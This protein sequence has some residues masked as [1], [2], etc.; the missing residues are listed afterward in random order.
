M[1]ERVY[2]SVERP[3]YA[4][5]RSNRSRKLAIGMTGVRIWKRVTFLKGTQDYEKRMRMRMSLFYI[6]YSRASR[7]VNKILR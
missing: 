3:E 6:R 1:L 7:V 5:G 2:E 4:C